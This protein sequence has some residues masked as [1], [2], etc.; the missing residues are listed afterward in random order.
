M[1]AG[2]AFQAG[3]YIEI[4]H[5]EGNIPL[6]VASAPWRLPALHLHYRSTPGLAEAE[7]MDALLAGADHLTVAGPGGDVSLSPPLTHP[8]LIVAGGTGIA[9]AES[10]V[11]AFTRQPPGATVTLVW[12]ADREADFYLAAELE[13]LSPPWLRLVCIADPERGPGNRGL[14]WLTAHGADFVDA[15]VVLAGSPGFVYAACD[16]LL[17][18]GVSRSNMQS[19][20]FSY[21][22]R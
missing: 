5:P 9:Q 20:V 19:D 18:A 1:P 2:F 16:A 12:C 13:D 15:S 17:A 4:V 21:A 3:Q 7:R 6:S 11:D 22:P 14:S 10:F 8:A